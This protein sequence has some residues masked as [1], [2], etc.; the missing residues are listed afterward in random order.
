MSKEAKQEYTLVGQVFETYWIVEYRDQMYIIDQHAAHERVLY[1]RTLKR[2][3]EKQFTSQ[4]ISPPIV[5]NLSM[6]EEQLYQ[7]IW[8]ILQRLDLRS[9]LLEGIPMPSV[10]FQTICSVLQKKDLLIEMLDSLSDSISTNLAPDIVLE[11]IA[12]MSC[13][14]A[15][16]GTP[17]FLAEKWMR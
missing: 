15:V 6:Q 11:K 10:Q 12:S 7:N 2:M 8:K 3:K 5:L 17:G 4:R 13:K 14:A 16:K 9:S 1:E